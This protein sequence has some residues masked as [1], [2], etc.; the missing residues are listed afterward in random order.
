MFLPGDE[1]TDSDV[2]GH[3]HCAIG[4]DGSKQ[5]QWL[6]GNGLDRISQ[7]DALGNRVDH[8]FKQV[9]APLEEVGRG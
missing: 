5:S 7:R 1:E 2:T 4:V 6:H 9:L 3:G 8:P